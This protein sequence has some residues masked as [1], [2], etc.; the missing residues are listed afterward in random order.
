MIPSHAAWCMREFLNGKT[1]TQIAREIGRVQISSVLM[2][3]YAQFGWWSDEFRYEWNYNKRRNLYF[4]Q[5]LDNYLFAGFEIL[6]PALVKKTAPAVE[7]DHSNE[8]YPVWADRG[9]NYPWKTFSRARSEHAWLLRAEGLTYRQVGERLGGLSV[10]R[11]QQIVG[12]QGRR[13]SRALRRTIFK[14][15]YP[16]DRVIEYYSN[17]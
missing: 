6:E 10:A 14:F 15:E 12:T 9:E 1:Q 17:W 2:T 11:A 5:A 7:P 4:R 13:M 3:F 8:E 16:E